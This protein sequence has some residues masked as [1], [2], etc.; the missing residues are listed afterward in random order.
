MNESGR[1]VDFIF[2]DEKYTDPRTGVEIVNNLC[3]TVWADERMKEVIKG[4][5]GV[6]N[7]YNIPTPTQFHV[8]YDQRYDR[9]ALKAEISAAIKNAL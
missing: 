9:D 3:F 1:K 7:V 5:E 6:T 8:Y 2:E 4:V